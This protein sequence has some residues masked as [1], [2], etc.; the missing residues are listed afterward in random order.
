VSYPG[1][2]PQADPFARQGSPLLAAFSGLVGLGVAGVLVW[3]TLDLLSFLGDALSELPASWTAMIVVHFAIAGIA[4][5]G[6]M[7]V[8][9]RRIAG[10]FILLT[11]A[12]LTVAALLAA[13]V[14]VEEVGYTLIN[15]VGVTDFGDTNF[16]NLYFDRLFAFEFDNTQATLR[17]AALALG[18]LLLIIAVLPP[19]L[20]WLRRPRRNVYSEQPTRW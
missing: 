5:I 19:S 6:A 7:L 18:V 1:Y 4:V 15:L 2:D 20:N 16:G 10:A 11:S 9:A 12:L 13:P 17:L 14:L 3:Q 8:F